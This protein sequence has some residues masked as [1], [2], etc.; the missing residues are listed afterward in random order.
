[1]L[2]GVDGNIRGG[3]HLS[4]SCVSTML[5]ICDRAFVP[6]LPSVTRLRLH[7]L[8]GAAVTATRRGAHTAEIWGLSVW[9]PQVQGQG[10]GRAVPSAEAEAE[11]APWLHPLSPV[12]RTPGPASLRAQLPSGSAARTDLTG[13]PSSGPWW[14]AGSPGIP[15]HLPR[16]WISVPPPGAFSL[17]VCVCVLPPKDTSPIGLGPAPLTSS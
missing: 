3:F 8:A 10:V 4:F 6:L 11:A 17:S 7:W 1:M 12:V 9:R 16:H 14:S 5:I 2:C 13:L 15:W